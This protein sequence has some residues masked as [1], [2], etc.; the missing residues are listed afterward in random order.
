MSEIAGPRKS[1]VTSALVVLAC[2]IAVLQ[3]TQI[4]LLKHRVHTLEG[5]AQVSGGS[6]LFVKADGAASA[7]LGAVAGRAV[8]SVQSGRRAVT[9]KLAAKPDGAEVSVADGTASV[10]LGLTDSGEPYL[11]GIARD[12][13]TVF[14][15]PR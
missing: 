11:E 12:G 2:A 5:Q 9:A 10:R 1:W 13:S 8:V 4:S 3:Q 14:K 15:L 6:G 7:T